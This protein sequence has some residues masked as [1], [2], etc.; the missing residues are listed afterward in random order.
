MS[1]TA[2]YRHF[3]DMEELG[4]VLVEESLGTLR[5]VI[6]ELRAEA[7]DQ[8][9]A[10][11][12]TVRAIADYVLAHQPHLRFIA[13]ERWGGRRGLRRQIRREIQLFTDELAVDLAGY[14]A[15]AEWSMDDRRVLAGLLTEL[16]VHMSVELLDTSA[17]E[18]E[19]IIQQTLQQMRL[20]ILGVPNWK[21]R[22]PRRRAAASRPVG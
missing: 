17:S 9:L 4:L 20:A 5:V 8:S 1:P 16:V 2:F 11:A 12:K 22:A 15:L 3:E 18:R 7:S 13:R 21:P 10:L 19:A 14:D 6:R